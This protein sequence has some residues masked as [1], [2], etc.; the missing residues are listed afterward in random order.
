MLTVEILKFIPI[1]FTYLS[2]RLVIV[3]AFVC[4]ILTLL[5]QLSPVLYYPPVRY[6]EENYTLFFLSSSLILFKVNFQTVPQYRS[7]DHR[8]KL[9]ISNAFAN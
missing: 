8:I 7:A 2:L 6:G 4:T 5:L 1:A 9:E 3:I